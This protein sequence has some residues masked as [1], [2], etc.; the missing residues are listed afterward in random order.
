MSAVTSE[1][2]TFETSHDV[3]SLVAVGGKP[4]IAKCCAIVLLHSGFD[5]ARHEQ[6]C[7]RHG[8]FPS[9]TALHLAVGCGS[10]STF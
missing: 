6:R 10:F 5:T 7:Y 8:N 9:V 1:I 3:R 4:D 2:G